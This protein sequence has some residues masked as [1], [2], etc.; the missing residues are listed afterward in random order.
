M[1]EGFEQEE[2]H[3]SMIRIADELRAAE[4]GSII[5]AHNEMWRRKLSRPAPL[6]ES[7]RNETTHIRI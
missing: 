7:S 3:E 6:R 4:Q 2:A 5:D 1:Q